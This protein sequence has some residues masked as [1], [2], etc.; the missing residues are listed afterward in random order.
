MKPPKNTNFQDRLT[1]AA[2]AKTAMREKF[3]ARPGPDDPAVIERQ[4]AQMAIAAAREA[5][6]QER[7]LAREADAARLAAEKVAQPTEATEVAHEYVERVGEIDPLRRG[8]AAALEPRLAVTVVDAALIGIAQHL[9]GARDLL[10]AFL[11]LL[12]SLVL[13][14]VMLER[15]LSVRLLD[16]FGRG[17][18]RHAK[19][20]IVVGHEA[21]IR[22]TRED[23]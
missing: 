17:F 8:R 23:V 4:A 2:K 11:G 1:V 19:E 14:R 7:K 15:D 21:R 6:T 22:F 20:L 10:E 5:R 13:V 12:R 18:A 9:V 16:L 3:Q